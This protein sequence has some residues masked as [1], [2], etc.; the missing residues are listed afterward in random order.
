MPLTPTQAG[1]V[2]TSVQGG[3]NVI[4]SLIQI[5]ENRKNREFNAQQAALAYQRSVEQWQR[6]NEYNL[7]ARQ[8]QRYLDAGLNPN[9]IYG[10][11]NMAAPAPTASQA[12]SSASGTVPLDVQSNL[13]AA[14]QVEAQN[15]LA[16]AQ[17]NNINELT[18]DQKREIQSRW[19]LNDQQMSE[20]I[21]RV[22]Q[23]QAT[24]ELLKSQTAFTDAQT[25]GQWLDNAFNEQTFKDRAQSIAAQAQCDLVEAQY[26][27]ALA[28]Q[29]LLLMKAQTG[30]AL[31]QAQLNRANEQ[32]ARYEAV[33]GKYRAGEIMACMKYTIAQAKAEAGQALALEG[34]L[35]FNK[36][37]QAADRTWRLTLGAVDA[38]AGVAGAVSKF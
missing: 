8:M 7:P 6:E 29:Q 5:G 4:S 32:V 17:A 34:M 12:S 16:E 20:S 23:I 26:A 30:V 1:L 33:L 10:Q 2:D 9:L 38:A 22:G 25:A 37:H 31:S 18:P 27:E 13:L 3:S 11:Q 36:D 35:N 28:I 15:K 21:A 14:K 24:A 19:H